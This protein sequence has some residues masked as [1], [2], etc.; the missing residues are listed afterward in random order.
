MEARQQWAGLKG[1]EEADTACVDYDLRGLVEKE[2][3]EKNQK[4]AKWK[5]GI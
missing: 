5:E 1:N 2:R 4:K 3:K